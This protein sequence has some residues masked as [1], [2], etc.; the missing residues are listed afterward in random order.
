MIARNT[1][2]NSVNMAVEALLE[3][4]GDSVEDIVSEVSSE[5][6]ESMAKK[7]YPDMF[8]V[9]EMHRYQ[10]LLQVMYMTFSDEHKIGEPNMCSLWLS[11]GAKMKTMAQMS[12]LVKKAKK[13]KMGGE[14]NG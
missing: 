9:E 3:V 7:V 10:G 4:L 8:N 6:L 12:A 5:E 1:K 11:L 2:E 13:K 14:D